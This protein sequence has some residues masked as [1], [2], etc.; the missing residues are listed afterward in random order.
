MIIISNL[1]KRFASG[2]VVDDV[3]FSVQSGEVVCLVGPNGAGKTTI[4][5]ILAGYVPAT[6]GTA[7]IDGLDVCDYSLEC[8]RRIG[9]L[10]ENLGLYPDMRVDEFLG[11]RAALKGVGRSERRS[12]VEEVK[13]LCGLKEYGRGIICRL[14]RGGR[15][16]VGMADAMIHDPRLLILDEPTI[17]LDP[18]EARNIRKLI[19]GLGNRYTV[20]MSTH[21]LD[22]A[23][24]T[25]RRVIVLNRGRILADDAPERLVQ[26]NREPARAC[27]EIHGPPG[28]IA[29]VLERLHGVSG[30]AFRLCGGQGA[31]T[32]SENAWHRYT[33]EYRGESDIR[34]NI[35][36]VS[37]REKWKLR[38]LSLEKR[39]LKDVFSE[40]TS[41]VNQS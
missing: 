33:I 20:L 34:A 9:Y 29:R 27:A 7:T 6:S 15:Q 37:V 31:A 10:P 14:S 23:E 32:E 13:A 35:F 28:G 4:M 5:R 16:M 8:R 40:M 38:E 12:R 1:T 39:S 11:F 36:E 22:E 19:A 2:I 24:E 30:V 26:N 41:G 3:S 21:F 17:G 18:N 25:G